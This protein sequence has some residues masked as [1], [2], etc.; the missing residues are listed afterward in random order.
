MRNIYKMFF[1]SGSFFALTGSLACPVMAADKELL[2]ILL[3]NQSITQEQYDQLMTKEELTAADADEII[4]TFGGGS[5]LHVSSADGAYEVEI[6]GRL[7]LDYVQHEH[8]PEMGTLP[9]NGSHTRRARLELNGILAEH[10]GWASEMDFAGNQ[11]KLKDVKMGYEAENFSLYA[12][13][14]KQPYSLSLEMS[15]NDIPWTERSIDNS[16]VAELTDRA[17]GLRLETSGTNW[18]FAGGIFGEELDSGTQGDESSAV[19]GRFV[20]APVIN[21][22]IVVH[23]GIRRAFRKSGDNAIYRG[24][25][26]T[27]DWSNLSIVDTGTLNDIDQASMYGPEFAVAFGPLTV[28]GEYS[29]V[30]LDRRL[31]ADLS[32]NSWHIGAALSLTGDSR[33]NAYRIGA[34]EFKDVRAKQEF[35]PAR[36]QWG[37][38]EVQARFAS[39]DLND[40]AFTGGSEEVFNAGLNWY[41]NRNIRFLFD[42]AHIVDTDESNTIRLYAPGM[43][44]YTLRAQYNY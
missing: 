5:G 40:G 43:N 10:W 27:T 1:M 14:Q 30:D 12:G 34:G 7:H 25:D 32:F 18:F 29:N 16:I 6:G 38:F 11:V 8:I 3:A 2:D 35:D 23:L 24:R 22:D 28:L 9:V 33:V 26:E 39:V 19:M 15:S 4:V 20:Y 31:N 36:N 42:W 37:G 41:L 17:I 13:H 21:D 44:F